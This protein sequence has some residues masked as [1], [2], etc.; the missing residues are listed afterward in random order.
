MNIAKS[1]QAQPP[2]NQRPQKQP[3]QGTA[4]HLLPATRS[5]ESGLRL[6]VEITTYQR[7]DNAMAWLPSA[8]HQAPTPTGPGRRRPRLLRLA[9]R[10]AA[11][12]LALVLLAAFAVAWAPGSAADSAPV[13]PNDPKT[14][15]TVTAD[16]LPTAQH[17][18]VAWQ[19]AIIGNTVYVVGKFNNARPYNAAP[20]TQQV[21][22]SNILAF[23][24]ATGQLIPG[25]A[26]VL[27]AQALAV[28]AAPDGSRLYIG[29]DFTTVNGVQRLRVAALDPVTGSLISTFAPQMSATVRAIA[30][31][32][33]TV[34]LGGTFTAVGSAARSRLAAVNAADGSLLPW[35]PNAAGGQVNAL[36]V[37]PD[38]AKIVV[39]GS[40]ST[41]NGSNRPGFGLGM[42]NATSGAN[43]ATQANDVVRNSGSTSAILSLHSDGTSFYGTGFIKNTG[44][45]LEG[46]FSANWSDARIKW[47]E[48]CHGDSYG[49]FASNTAVYVASHAHYCLNLGGFPETTPK[50]WHRATAFS[51]AATGTLTKDTQ[52]YPSFTGQPAPTLLNWFPDM[53]TGTATGQAQGPWAVTGNSNYVVMVG[54]FLNVNLRPQQGLSRFAVKEIAPNRQQPRVNPTNFVPT[55]TSPAAGEVK[56]D[57]QSNWDRDNSNLT[58][59]VLRDGNATPVYSVSGLSTFWQ[60]P[61][62]TFTDSGL[63][64][65][66]H[67]Y[68]IVVKDPFGNT[69][70]GDS[71]SIT[72]AVAGNQAPAAS[73]TATVNQLAV[74]VDGAASADPDGTISGYAWNFGDGG[75][76]TGATASHSYA[77]AGTYTVTLTV[78][79]NGGATGTTTRSVTVAPAGGAL[80]RD[81]FARTLASGWGTADTGGAWS[82]NGSASSYSAGGGL[83]L[84]SLIAGRGPSTFLPGVS[85]TASNSL[86]TVSFDKIGNGG[87]S[88]LGVIGR[89]VGT[90]EY[91]GK[92]KVSSTGVTTLQLTRLAGGAETTLAQVPAGITLTAGQQLQLRVEVTGTGPSTLRART[93]RTGTAEPGAWGVTIT[94]S[95]ASL[96]AAG[97]TGLMSYLSG[98]AT[99]APVLARFDDLVVGPA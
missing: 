9:H 35:A 16:S 25:F 26:P 27:N 40:F 98:S 34:W 94:D 83:G 77:A 51:K 29:G 89:R 57:W 18:G 86:V 7:R 33:T 66:S 37:S 76:A 67:S 20:G 39:G 93:W 82:V 70:T 19:T 13:D 12:V 22:R 65:G 46:A 47:V 92:V 60:R 64:A 30:A 45:N 15:V 91:R 10:A 4:A 6:M 88:N 58:Y 49:V 73:F 52:G 23:N 59:T 84:M 54:E 42:V 72:V 80:A 48:D 14:P 90:E 81:A 44:G 36:T 61:T 17:D 74:A 50:S 31:K 75:T 85:T 78:T 11:M 32:G 56:V 97:S 3:P 63:A 55:L 2:Q 5:A 62:L 69:V 79:D 43:I 53:D 96:Q 24:L 68:R 87:G 1:P 99:N 28:A 41:L 95:T 21:P 8:A 71:R 38:G